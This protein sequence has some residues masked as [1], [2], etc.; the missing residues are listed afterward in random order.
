MLQVTLNIGWR[1]RPMRGTFSRAT[2]YGPGILV[3][4][5]TLAYVSV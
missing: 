1:E 4:S 3:D 2:V 5:L